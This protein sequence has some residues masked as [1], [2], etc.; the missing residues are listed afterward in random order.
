MLDRWKIIDL[1]RKDLIFWALISKERSF[2]EGAIVVSSDEKAVDIICRK[3]ILDKLL[4]VGYVDYFECIKNL[5]REVDQAWQRYAFVHFNKH[6]L[7]IADY[8]DADI[9]KL[10]TLL[11]H[12]K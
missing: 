1:N 7:E 2:L 8:Q 6:W 4:E 11:F 9:E 3:Y 5:S 12:L 10:K